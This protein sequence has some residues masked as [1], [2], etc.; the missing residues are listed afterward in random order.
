M[1]KQ[2]P[3]RG[4]ITNISTKNYRIGGGGGGGGGGGELRGGLGGEGGE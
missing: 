4:A 2:E 3:T 1:S